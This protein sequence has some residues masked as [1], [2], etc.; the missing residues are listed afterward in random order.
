M[1][2]LKREGGGGGKEGLRLNPVSVPLGPLQIYSEIWL[3]PHRQHTVSSL[4]WPINKC[5]LL[6]IIAVYSEIHT[7]HTNTE[8]RDCEHQT[9]WCVYLPVCFKSKV[10]H[11]VSGQCL[12]IHAIASQC[13]TQK[14][15]NSDGLSAVRVTESHAEIN[16]IRSLVCSW[17][18]ILRRRSFRRDVVCFGKYQSLKGTSC[19]H[20]APWSWRQHGAQKSWFLCTRGSSVSTGGICHTRGST[21]RRIK[22]FLSSPYRSDRL[23]GHAASCGILF[24]G[25]KPTSHYVRSMPVNTT[26]HPRTSS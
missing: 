12:P 18:I 16:Y 9:W 4:T 15:R 7:K 2:I 10:T 5:Y 1:E 3:L 11:S 26:S 24:M 21:S 14:T 6:K 17:P 23:W 20:F 19:V 8:A 25:E 22:N 13:H